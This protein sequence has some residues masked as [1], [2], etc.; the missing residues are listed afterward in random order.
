MKR[1]IIQ[2][3]LEKKKEEMKTITVITPSYNRAHTLPLCYQSLQEQTSSD[4]VWVIVDDGSVDGTKELVSGWLKEDNRFQIV[5]LQKENGGKAS[6][7][8]LAFQH[9]ETPYA[10]V[11][12]SDDT[13]TPHAIETAI[14]EITPY[15]DDSRCCGLMAFRHH[16]DG[17]VM[18]GRELKPGVKISMLDILNEDYRTELICIYRSD[19]LKRYLFPQFPGEKFVSPQWLDFEL[20]RSYY[21]ISSNSKICICEYEE[22]GLT[23]NKRTIIKKNPHGY[24][25]VKRQ[26]FEFSKSLKL[27]I[28]HGI[29]YDCGCIIGRD[30]NWLRRSPR[31]MLSIVL[32]PMAYLVYF[33]RFKS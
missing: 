10:I 3:Q 28:K 14:K 13:F 11:L 8:N 6:A 16:K 24:T 7:L 32:M 33:L 22:D 19:I 9:L 27:S 20:S 26:S 15:D 29:M 18:G 25:A 4:F 31:K 12:D 23:K 21:Y 2:V 17:S 1:A 30:K 5:Y